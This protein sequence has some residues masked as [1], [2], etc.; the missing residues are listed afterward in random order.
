MLVYFQP[1]D[2]C[3]LQRAG[4]VLAL[5]PAK[6][7]IWEAGD[8]LMWRAERERD[9]DTETAFAMATSGDLIK[10][11]VHPRECLQ[12]TSPSRTT[13]SWDEWCAGMDGLGGLVMLSAALISSS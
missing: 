10:L 5:L 6:K 3:H 4:I 2:L 9:P 11:H 7:Q 1:A 12:A 8:E 13:A